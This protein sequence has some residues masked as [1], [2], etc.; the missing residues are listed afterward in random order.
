MFAKHQPGTPAKTKSPAT[1]GHGE[2]ARWA[3]SYNG[4]F[5]FG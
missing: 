2:L 3:G 4:F 1:I 5:I